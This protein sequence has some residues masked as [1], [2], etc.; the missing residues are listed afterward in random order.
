ML[1]PK[2]GDNKAGV[3]QEAKYHDEQHYK[4]ESI[5]W[6][7]SRLGQVFGDGI[8]WVECWWCYSAYLPPSLEVG[9]MYV[10]TLFTT[11]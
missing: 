8:E 7:M 2:L 9:T 6:W 5:G 1:M 10:C 4:C 3:V 11:E